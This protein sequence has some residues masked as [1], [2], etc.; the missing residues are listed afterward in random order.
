MKPIKE[1]EEV[2]E[3]GELVK[4]FYVYLEGQED[5]IFFQTWKVN[6]QFQCI[7][8]PVPKGYGHFNTRATIEEAEEYAF[9]SYNLWLI[10]NNNN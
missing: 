2:M 7:P 3:Y 1:M 6:G 10:Q 9:S 8:N 4:T 5:K